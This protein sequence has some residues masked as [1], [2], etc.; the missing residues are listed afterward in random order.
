MLQKYYEA[1]GYEVVIDRK[2]STDTT[3]GAFNAKKDGNTLRVKPFQRNEAQVIMEFIGFGVM[4]KIAEKTNAFNVAEGNLEIS[5]DDKIIAYESTYIPNFVSI[6]AANANAAPRKKSKYNS[7]QLKQRPASL[8]TPHLLFFFASED[9]RSPDNVENNG[10]SMIDFGRFGYLKCSDADQMVRKF[11]RNWEGIYPPSM[12]YKKMDLSKALSTT[13]SVTSELLITVLEE[14]NSRVAILSTYISDKELQNLSFQFFNVDNDCVEVRKFN[15]FAE[16][17]ETLKTQLTFNFNAFKPALAADLQQKIARDAIKNAAQSPAGSSEAFS[18]GQIATALVSTVRKRKSIEGK[19]NAL[20]D[21][22]T[23]T[24]ATAYADLDSASPIVRLAGRRRT[25][26]TP[27][28]SPTGSNSSS[29]VASF[30][31]RFAFDASPEEQNTKKAL[32]FS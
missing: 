11:Y 22:E 13:N 16:L 10:I 32:A 15:S 12:G 1:K 17:E 8:E 6:S 18:F 4:Q 21:E 19:E 9:D 28:H 7:T 25:F 27:P 2:T 3:S 30:A 26:E 20:G 14:V 31:S 24:S 5:S 29:P 23:T